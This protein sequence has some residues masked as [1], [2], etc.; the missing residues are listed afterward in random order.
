MASEIANNHVARGSHKTHFAPVE[1]A[2]PKDLQ[3]DLRILSESPFVD[4]LMQAAGGFLAVLNEQRQILAVNDAFLRRLNIEDVKEVL[5]LR[6]GEALACVHACD[7]AGGCGTGPLCA[8]CGAVIAMMA[9][10][11]SDTPQQRECVA[12]VRKDDKPLDFYFVIHCSPVQ[13]G[14]ARYLLLFLQDVTV[15]QNRATLEKM[16]FHD[17]QNMIGA[18]TLN[19]RLLTSLPGSEDRQASQDRIFQI[20]TY[21]AKEVEMQRVLV[22]DEGQAYCLDFTEVGLADVI[23]DVREVATHHPAASGKRLTRPVPLGDTRV[24]TDVSLLRRVLINMLLNAFEATRPGHAVK[25]TVTEQ[26]EDIVFELWNEIPIPESIAL[27]VFQRNFSTKE[28]SG[29]GLGTYTMKLFGETY[30]GGQVTF[31]SSAGAGTVFRFRLPKRPHS[32]VH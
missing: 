30:L 31:S 6:L 4:G 14:A 9:A 19:T 18:L 28:G 32:G 17:V 8:S 15:S 5:G 26:E 21:L 20:A 7:E 22:R 24:V 1:R 23:Q 10:L 13:V 27:R 12:T 3:S 11:S 2:A 16:F 25:L 29:R